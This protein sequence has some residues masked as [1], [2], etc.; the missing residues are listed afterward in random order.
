VFIG[1][2][3]Y[4]AMFHYQQI[5]QRYDETMSFARLYITNVHLNENYIHY[6]RTEECFERL[7]DLENQMI[8]FINEFQSICS[9]FFTNDIGPE[10][11]LTYF[12]DDFRQVQ[13]RLD[14]IIET[15]KT[16][17]TWFQ[18]PIP[19][20]ISKIEVKRRNITSIYSLYRS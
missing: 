7:L 19:K 10:W 12:M 14:F 17:S 6:K 13:Q 11:L 5:K 16:Q 9:L 2:E 3:L 4:N 20:N 8:T 18:R 1:H 15:L